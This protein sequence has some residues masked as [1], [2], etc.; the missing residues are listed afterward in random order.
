MA[1]NNSLKKAAAEALGNIGPDA[2]SALPALKE[3]LEDK[4]A[5]RDREL[6]T[7]IQAAVRKIERAS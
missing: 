5:G 6:R 7:I 2:R 1:R 3:V 4:Q